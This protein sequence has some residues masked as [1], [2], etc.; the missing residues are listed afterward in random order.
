MVG[1]VPAGEK[2]HLEEVG[3]MLDRL[4]E[5]ERTGVMSAD[6]RGQVAEVTA[7]GRRYREAMAEDRKPPRRR[8]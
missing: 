5:I 8:R 2:E 7:I 3:P 1:D 4:D 6:L